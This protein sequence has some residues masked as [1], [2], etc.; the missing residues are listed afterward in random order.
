MLSTENPPS[1]LCEI[2]QLK[3]GD[4]GSCESNQQQQL[5]GVDLLKSGLDDKNPLPNFSIR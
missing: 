1:D 2:P 4:D 3:S 5:L